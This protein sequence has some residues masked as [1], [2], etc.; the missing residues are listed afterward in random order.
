M[1]RG[2]LLI[3]EGNRYRHKGHNSLTFNKNAYYWNSRG[4]HGN[5]VDFLVSFYGMKF[6]DAVASL[7]GYTYQNIFKEPIVPKLEVNSLAGDQRRAIA[8]LIKTR[9]IDYSVVNILLRSKHIF[10]EKKTNNILF[11]IYDETGEYVGA[12]VQGTLSGKRF[13]GIKA[14]SKYGYGFNIQLTMSQKPKYALFFESC[15]DLLSFID[16]KMLREKKTLN[17]CILISMGGLKV[18]VVENMLKKFAADG[19]SLQPVMCI[20]NDYASDSFLEIVSERGIQFINCKPDVYAKDY[21]ELLFFKKNCFNIGRG[22]ME[23]A[24]DNF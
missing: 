13:K 4:E 3:R 20:D 8:Y 19:S 12:E 1:A 2:E 15:V 9:M 22:Y 11:P 24:L 14:K 7:T 18:C 5:A 21:N 23:R 17:R 10:Q 6:D 16:L